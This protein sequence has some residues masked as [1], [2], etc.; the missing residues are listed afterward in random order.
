MTKVKIMPFPFVGKLCYNNSD[1]L[2]GFFMT[3]KKT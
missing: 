2:I 1:V 3:G